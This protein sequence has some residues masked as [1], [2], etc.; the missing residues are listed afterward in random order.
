[1]TTAMQFGLCLFT[2]GSFSHFEAY[3]S[4][5]GYDGGGYQNVEH[6]FPFR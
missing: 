6:T 4:N 2:A 1:M 5:S 3:P